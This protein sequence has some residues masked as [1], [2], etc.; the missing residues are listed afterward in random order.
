[1]ELGEDLVAAHGVN[2]LA[3]LLGVSRQT[4]WLWRKGTH[5]PSHKNYVKMRALAG[6]LP[7]NKYV[8]TE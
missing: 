2:Q 3:R 4:V 7:N 8:T 5:R 1:M 6:Q